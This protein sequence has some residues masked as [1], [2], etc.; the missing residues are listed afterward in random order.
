MAG[1]V[2]GLAA[3][4]IARA[5]P[6]AGEKFRPE[7]VERLAAAMARRPYSAPTQ[8]TGAGDIGYDGYWGVAFRREKA[9]WARAGLKFQADYLPAGYLFPTPVRLFEVVDGRAVQIAYS[10]ADF[11]ADPEWA[12]VLTKLSDISGFRLQSPI[13]DP[14]KFDE[15]AVFQGASYFRS[16]GRDEAYGLSARG[17]AIRT[18]GPN[19][20]FPIF[21]AFWIERPAAGAGEVVIHA[22]LDGPSVAGAYRF[23]IAPG[24][25]TVF[26]VQAKL[27]PRRAIDDAGVAPQTSM[28]LFGAAD[29]AGVDD[30]RGAVHDSDGLEIWTGQGERIWRPLTNPA[31]VQI[32]TFDD[33]SPKG[34]GLAQRLRDL[35][36]YGDYQARYDRRPGLWVE[37]VGDWGQGAVHLV[38][39]P[40]TR[41]ASDNVVAFWRPAAGWA[42][43]VPVELRYR[44][45]WGAGNPTKFDVAKVRRTR[46]GGTVPPGQRQFA[47]D[48]DGLTLAKDAPRAQATASAGTI[49]FLT[50]SDHPAGDAVRAA[51]KFDPPPEGVADLK[52]RLANDAGDLTETWRFRWTA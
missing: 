41:E 26:D 20:E 7:Q 32:T 9:L 37:P 38:E 34:F 43:G 40:A 39:L 42:P 16:L 22:L 13:N 28:F 29:R 30:F 18:E 15:I 19:E 48:F 50:V 35:D 3:P 33:V 44:L 36:A 25:R 8:V 51:F 1:L 14:G 4:A 21:R 6:A 47:V 12:A 27:F 11:Q 49:S 5:R 17:L 24:E 10:A 45:H 31:R 52:L 46:V 2:L 23:Q